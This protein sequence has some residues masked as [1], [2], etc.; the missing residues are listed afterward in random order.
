VLEIDHSRTI[1]SRNSSPD[2]PFD[3]SVNPYRGCEHGCI[4][5]YARPTHA[6]LGLSPGLDF[7]RRL[8]YKPHAARQLRAEL[9]ARD[10]ACAPMG[11]GANTDAYQPVERRLGVTREILQVLAGCDH[12]VRIV[13]KSALVERDLDLLEPMA[14]KRL[15]TVCISVTTLDP[16]LARRMEPRANAPARRLLAIRRL[17]ERGIPVGVLAAPMIPA[18]NDAELESILCAAYEAGARS[19][20]YSVLRL[21]LE[22]KTLFKEWLAEH[23]PLKATHVMQRVRDMRGGREYDPDFSQ[24]MHGRGIYADLLARRFELYRTRLGYR[25]EPDLETRLFA[26]PRPESDQLDLF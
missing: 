9:A 18:L 25:P 1:I 23:E 24:R 21:P 2:V 14:A 11:L 10:Y 13:T 7:E 4:Y 3:R 26:P 5:C 19:A 17:S 12:P 20:S 16:K 15:C 8:F 22:I 6:W